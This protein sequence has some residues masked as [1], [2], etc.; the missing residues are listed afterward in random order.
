[1]DP[2]RVYVLGHSNGAFMAH[3]LACDRAGRVRAIVALN[4]AGP[5]DPSS[6][7]PEAPVGVLEVH[8]D[9]DDL[10]LYEGGTTSRGAAYPSAE[11]TVRG[12]AERNGCAGGLVDGPS[13]DL[14]T[15]LDGAETRA[16]AMTG[17]PA[18][19]SVDLWTM[20]GGVHIP[21]LGASWAAEVWAYLSATAHLGD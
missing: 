16:R 14:D 10:I 4:G 5:S 18:G 2:R 8:G 3:R 7:R 13:K 9:A 19:G 12:W 11:D 20:Q 15:S 21:S 6:C 1:V 17:C